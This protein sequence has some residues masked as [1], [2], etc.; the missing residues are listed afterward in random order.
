MFASDEACSD[1]FNATQ[2]KEV[3]NPTSYYAVH[4]LS[5]PCYTLQHNAYA[6]DGWLAVRR[7]LYQFVYEASRPLGRASRTAERWT[8]DNVRGV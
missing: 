3:E 7:L 4:H 1:R 8:A 5:V 6:R 2:I